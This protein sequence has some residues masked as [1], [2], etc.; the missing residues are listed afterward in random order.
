LAVS[1][2]GIWGLGIDQFTI[3][4]DVYTFRRHG[5]KKARLVKRFQ[6]TVL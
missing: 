4:L 6:I 5:N 1:G 2:G 3:H